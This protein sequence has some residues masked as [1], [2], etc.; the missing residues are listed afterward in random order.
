M[1]GKYP[2]AQVISGFNDWRTVSRYRSQA[3]LQLGY[4]VAL[5][6]GSN[7]PAVWGGRVVAIVPWYGPQYGIS[8]ESPDGVRTTY[9]HLVPLVTTGQVLQPGQSVGRTVIDHVDVK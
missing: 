9:G 8:V 3:G 7:V 5:P 4:D 2:G 1:R 6:Y